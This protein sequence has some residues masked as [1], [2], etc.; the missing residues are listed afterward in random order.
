[1]RVIAV[2][3]GYDRMGVAVM[4]RDG[5][6]E[7]LLYSTCIETE[8]SAPLPDRLAVLGER[9]DALLT[10]YQPELFGVETLFFNQNRTTAIAVAEARG[11][12]LFL[13]RRH[14]CN[15]AEF[16]PQ[17][18]KVAVTGYGKS[19]KTAVF[20]ML[21]RLVRDIPASAHD[22]EYD[23]IAIAVTTLAHHRA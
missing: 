7:H 12:A 8:R 23:A 18:V 15:I 9:F 13:A 22:D 17:E 5:S 14:G 21:N 16:G 2:D 10:E 1:M 19:D 4:E 11:I 20:E 3:P 6:T